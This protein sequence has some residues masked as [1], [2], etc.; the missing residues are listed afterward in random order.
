MP[1]R[2]ANGEG[3]QPYKRDDGRWQSIYTYIGKDGEH[4]RGSVSAQTKTEC[5]KKL[6]VQ[7]YNIFHGK[8]T[9]PSK[10]TV[11]DWIM[12]WYKMFGEPHWKS[13]GTRMVH[14]SNI[15]NHIIPALGSE[16]LQK[17]DTR[18]VQGFI[19]NLLISGKKTVTV[20][21]IM[22]PLRGALKK[23]FAL[24]MISKNPFDHIE[25]PTVRQDEVVHLSR[26]EM[27][28]VLEALPDNTHGRCCELILRTGLRKSEVAGLEWRDIDFEGQYNDGQGIIWVCRTKQYIKPIE[29]GVKADHQILDVKPTKSR[30][31]YR[32]IPMKPET[33]SLFQRQ[34]AEQ[35]KEALVAGSHWQGGRPDAPETPV[36][37]TR[38]GTVPDMAHA[39]NALQRACEEAA[40]RI[41]TLHPLRHSCLTEMAKGG[42]VGLRTLAEIAG[43][44]KPSF[45]AEKY[46]HS[47]LS[48]MS[49]ALDV[50]GEN[51]KKKQPK[52][53]GQ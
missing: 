11:A 9:E 12:E 22:E 35:R 18:H 1:K 30:K 7:T 48:A 34:L 25:L 39:R 2:R 5:A 23:A 27:M 46:L 52:K 37:A 20:H 43:H 13:N 28:A 47:D 29:N 6:A 44:E 26:P 4:K 53:R 50:L 33:H 49:D 14:L 31:G 36:F 32:Q 3:S 15:E 24:E 19:D 21:K 16:M 40:T 38:V 42:K 41:V 10:M 51:L 17:L 8:F 45:T